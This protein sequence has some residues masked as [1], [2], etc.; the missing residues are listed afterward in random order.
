MTKPIVEMMQVS[1]TAR[2][3]ARFAL[4]R[5][6]FRPFYLLASVFA[7]ASVALWALQ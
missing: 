7:A 1:S 2:P 6:G 5:L 4:W 3:P